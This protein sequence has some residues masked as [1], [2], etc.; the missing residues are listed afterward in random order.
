MFS[1]QK[2]KA[3]RDA[4]IALRLSVS[5][6]FFYAG[7]HAL[8]DPLNWLKFI[9]EFIG[10]FMQTETVLAVYGI[11]E[12]ILGVLILTGVK[13]RYVS[14]I[15]LMNVMVIIVGYGLDDSTFRDLGVFG[16]L[17][18]IFFLS[19]AETEKAEKSAIRA[20]RR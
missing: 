11:T 20:G 12:I 14:F 5:L 8:L 7:L 17:L 2:T 16:A 10:S 15:A 9:P 3:G 6:A 1:F 18:A 13:L 19:S 4:L